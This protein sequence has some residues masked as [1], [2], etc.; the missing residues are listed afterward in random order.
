MA[1]APTPTIEL[2]LNELQQQRDSVQREMSALETQLGDLES[3]RAQAQEQY[4][5]ECRLLDQGT[6]S[7]NPQKVRTQI[8]VLG[9]KADDLRIDISGKQA[10]LQQLS[11][12]CARASLEQQ[13]QRDAARLIELD[14]LIAQQDRKVQQLDEDYV[15]EHSQAVAM[16]VG[17]WDERNELLQRRPSEMQRFR[18][19]DGGRQ[20]MV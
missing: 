19:Q 12:A 13:R 11:E 18:I 16:R 7:A 10:A 5:Q 20:V 8:D 2:S 3:Q 9:V 1:T 15:R 17:L 4:R 6:K 14:S